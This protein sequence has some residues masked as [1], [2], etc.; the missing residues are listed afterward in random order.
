MPV[1]E[2]PPVFV[3]LGKAGA[4]K[5]ETSAFVSKQTGLPVLELGKFIRCKALQGDSHAEEIVGFYMKHGRYFPGEWSLRFV[6][7]A[8]SE[9][10]QKFKRGFI[11]DGFPRD[12]LDLAP[13]EEWLYAHRFRVGGCIELKIPLQVSNRRQAQRKGRPET[14][15]AQS[16]RQQEFLEKERAVINAFRKGGLLQTVHMEI[17]GRKR[18]IPES[19]KPLEL[20]NAHFL[21]RKGKQI[22]KAVLRLKRKPR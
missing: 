22:S 1:K 12:P 16:A 19:K 15:A 10:P 5:T 4:G 14:K 8:I 3:L 11:L 6:E 9:N 17:G 21:K 7:K 20:G 18:R 2:Y 13:F